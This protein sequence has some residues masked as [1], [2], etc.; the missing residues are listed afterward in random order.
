MK[1]MK[2]SKMHGLG[3]DFV[4]INN[5]D[6]S[7]H[8]TQAQIAAMADRHLGVGFDQLLLLQKSTYPDADFDYKIFNADG[9]EVEQCGNG[10]RCLALFIKLKKLS[11]KISFRFAT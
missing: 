5:L 11:P 1:I 4:V 3:N 2:F 6:D 8:L 9:T 7:I 10:A